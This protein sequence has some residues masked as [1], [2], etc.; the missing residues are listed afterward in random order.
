MTKAKM[1]K[2]EIKHIFFDLD[3]TLWDF[4]RNSAETLK[5]I[6]EDLNKKGEV[7]IDFEAFHQIYKPYNNNLW[8]LYRKEKISKDQLRIERFR[9]PLSQ[10]GYEDEVLHEYFA[11][12]YVEESP[13]KTGLFPNAIEIL[14]YLNQYYDLHIITNG[15]NEVQ[16][17]KLKYSNLE[18]FFDVIVTSE[19]VGVKKPN[20]QIFDFS[21]KKANAKPNNSVMIGDNF[22]ADIQGAL[23]A[24]MMAIYFNSENISMPEYCDSVPEILD[25][26]EIKNYL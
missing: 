14:N 16:F 15:F 17:T 13:K 18:E 1:D 26:I 3:H 2:K 19:N 12:T 10:L 5:E 23:D 6:V 4:E 22:E 20:K 24:G 7:S 8:D 11:N 9:Y 21:L 25:L